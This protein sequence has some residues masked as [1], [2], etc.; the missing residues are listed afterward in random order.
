[1]K[2]LLYIILFCFSVLTCYS[3]KTDTVV[4]DPSKV[5]TK[6]LKPGV[7]RWLVYFTKGKDSSRTNFNLWTRTIDFI[8]YKGREAIS[9]TQEWENDTSV[10][11]KVYSVC[12]R[13]TFAPLYQD[14]WWKNSGSA[15]FD[16]IEKTGSIK[17][18][19]LTDADT[20]RRKKNIYG[21]F[22]QALKEYVLNWHL[23]LETFPLLP[24]KNNTTFLINFYE[25]G[26]MPPKLQA[27]T[28]TGSGTLTGL[29]NE[30]IDCWLLT[31][32]TSPT[33][34][35]VFWISK[36]SK[37]VLKLEQQIG[38]RFRYKVKFGFA[39]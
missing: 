27:Y 23:D 5:N 39:S 14:S 28:V 36:K 33:N 12:D 26:S 35:E 19:L 25:A 16:F 15:K 17:D 10:T 1:M 11:H 30:K 20:S 6:V 2:I 13:K 31:H 37:E 22:K 3:Q 18:T 38:T 24:Y 21:A 8:T 29:D 32:T 7:H 34:N 4:I 9:V